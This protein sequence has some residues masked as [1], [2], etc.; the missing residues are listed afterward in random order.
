MTRPRMTVRIDA[1]EGEVL[2]IDKR[3]IVIALSEPWPG[4]YGMLKLVSA[5]EGM[6]EDCVLR[7][8]TISVGPQ[9]GFQRAL[10]D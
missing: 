5:K 7:T 10:N 6:S 9:G 4:I 8:V 1:S 2:R 3:G